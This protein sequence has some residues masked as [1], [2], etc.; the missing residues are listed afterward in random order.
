MIVSSKEPCGF[1]LLE[2]EPRLLDC[3]GLSGAGLLLAAADFMDT[4][5]ILGNCDMSSWVESQGTSRAGM[6]T[7]RC[8]AAA[9]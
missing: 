4:N 7:M 2:G 1:L 8:S 5:S 3:T 9:E 6:A